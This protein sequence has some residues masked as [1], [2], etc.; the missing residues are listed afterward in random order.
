MTTLTGL[1][2]KLYIG[3]RDLSGDIGSLSRI[4]GSKATL[5]FTSIEDE[6]MRRKGGLRD[7]SIEFVSYFN[8]ATGQA[9][10]TFSALPTTDVVCTYGAG[11]TLG[12][13]SACL[14][15]NQI[16]YDPN[17]G[18]DGS[19]T[20]TTQML[21]NGY[22]LDWTRQMTAGKRT[23]TAATD[24]SSVD[25]GTGSTTHG[26]QAYLQVFS[27]TGTDVTVKLQESSDNGVGDAW[28]DVTGG[29]FTQIT[30]G[31]T[32]QRIQ[33]S[34]TLTVERYLRVVTVTTGGF[35]SL[36]FHVSV[37][38]NKVATLL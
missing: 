27:F 6:G 19:L 13:I 28:V 24:G 17:R 20:N 16:N 30:S 7:G 26:L 25:F 23:D 15:G 3:G 35:T 36:V 33:T 32:S 9:H 12:D 4:G 22:G 1:A 18:N 10:P 21:G 11:T 2:N 8:N 37:R 38:R 5:D 29:G 34:R 31:P 14:V